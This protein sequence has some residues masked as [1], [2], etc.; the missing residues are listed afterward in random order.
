[1]H[2]K[3]PEMVRIGETATNATV[4]ELRKMLNRLDS[5]LFKSS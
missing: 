3:T 2:N 4:A 1:M 5:K